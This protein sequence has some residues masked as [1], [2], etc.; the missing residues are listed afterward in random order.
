MDQER[1]DVVTGIAVGTAS[2]NWGF[3]PLYTWVTTPSFERMLDEMVQAGYVATEI[4]Y[5]FPDDLEL[6]RQELQRRQLQAA[7]TFHAVNLRDRTHHKAA[8]ES[9]VR[10]ARRLQAL[11]ATVLI[12][13]DAPSPGRLAVAGRVTGADKLGRASWLAM[14]DGLQ[15]IAEGLAFIGIRVV[16][17][18]HVGTYVETREEIDRLCELTDASLVALCP[19]TGHLAYAG[20]DAE[21]LFC[22]YRERIG[23]VHL[24]DVDAAVL[25][26]V[27]AERVD[28]VEAVRRGMFVELGRGMVPIERIMNT[29][30]EAR[31]Y[32]WL[33]VEQDAPRDPQ[34]SAKANRDYLQANFG[35]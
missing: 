8:L 24:K 5:N 23:Y 26:R 14:A 32:G 29:L 35:L 20:V 30:R 7:A 4:S 10:V 13:S 12:L 11:G 21:Q 1:V 25:A 19:D 31:Y 6:L 27:Q 22:D 9:S 3:D 17:H 34:A 18:P 16:F 15:R 28:F 33:I 2:V